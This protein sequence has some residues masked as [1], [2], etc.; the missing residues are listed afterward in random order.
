MEIYLGTIVTVLGAL[1]WFLIGY[2][3]R[4][5]EESFDKGKLFKTVIAGLIVGILVVAFGVSEPESLNVLDILS[6]L[7][8]IATLERLWKILI[9]RLEG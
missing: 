7:G 8:A 4:E 5:P 1:I 6:R 2:Y 3:G 9:Q